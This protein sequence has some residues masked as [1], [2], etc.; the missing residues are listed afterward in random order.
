MCSYPQDRRPRWQQRSWAETRRSMVLVKGG[1][2]GHNGQPAERQDQRWV[3]ASR[4]R[5]VSR[6]VGSRTEARETPP[7]ALKPSP[8]WAQHPP[9]PELCAAKARLVCSRGARD[10]P[11]RLNPIYFGGPIP[12]STSG[13]PRN[14]RA[15][16]AP[17]RVTSSHP[18]RRLHRVTVTLHHGQR[19]GQGAQHLTPTIRMLLERVETVYPLPCPIHICMEGGVLGFHTLVRS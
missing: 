17:T 15:S 8:D 19:P 9:C 1:D 3:G 4:P 12:F 11:T 13:Q 16:C 18:S 14:S 10:D 7:I 2:S 6:R 5:V